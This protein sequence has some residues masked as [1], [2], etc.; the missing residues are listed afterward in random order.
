[1]MKWF[2]I[3]GLLFVSVSAHA[4]D[5]KADA[6]VLLQKNLAKAK[7]R[8]VDEVL[9]TDAYPN[10]SSGTFMVYVQQLYKDIRV[11]NAVRTLVF[12]DG[13]LV[14]QRGDFVTISKGEAAKKPAGLTA[15]QAL[16]RAIVYLRITKPA[17]FSETPIKSIRNKMEQTFSGSGVSQNAIP[18]TLMWLPAADGSLT[19]CWEIGI[20]PVE[21]ND[22]WLIRVGAES[23]KI[24]NQVNLTVYCNW[25]NHEIGTVTPQLHH[26]AHAIYPEPVQS[27][28][29]FALD[30]ASYRVIPYPFES[31]SHSGGTF[32]VVK[33]PWA[34]AGTGNAATTLKWHNDGT[35][36]YN[37]TRGNNVYAQEDT[38]QD[39]EFGIPATSSTAL[40]RLT[41]TS[42]FDPA[43]S[44]STAT[45]QAAAITNLFYWNNIIHDVLYQYGFD[46]VSGN[47][48]N[49]NSGR[50][51][52][53]GD[54]VIADAQDGSG[55]NN[56]NFST[57]PDGSRPR[58]QM[59][60]FSPPSGSTINRDGD[61]DNGI[62]V[63]EYAHGISNRLTG[64]ASQV[65]CL[66]NAEQMGEGWSDYYGLMLTTNWQNLQ[67]TD[68]GIS[69]PIGTYALAQSTTGSGIRTYPY[70]TNMTTNPLTYGQVASAPEGSV[71]Y[72]GSIWCTMIWDMTWEIIKEVGTISPSLYSADNTGGNAIAMRLVTE[73]L[74]IQPCSP[75]FV[76]GRDA[77]LTA[78][79][80]LYGGRYSCA[81][82]RAFARR[83]LGWSASQGSPFSYTDQV[84]AFDTPSGVISKTTAI[85]TVEQGEEVTYKITVDCRCAPV[86]NQA[87]IDSLPIGSTYVSGGTYNAAT[88]SVSF[89]NI[90]LPIGKDT[91]FFLKVINT[92][93]FST[94]IV[95]FSADGSSL[96]QWVSSQLVGS[97]SWGVTQT[98]SKSPSWSWHMPN[99]GDVATTALTSPPYSLGSGTTLFSFWH[100]LDFEDSFDGGVVE[101]S[102]DNGTSWSDLGNYMTQN[103]YNFTI[104]NCCGTYIS[105]KPAFSGFS[106]VFEET[107]VDLSSFKN[108][109]IRLR[110]LVSEDYSVN[111]A[112]W[113]I[114][115]VRLSTETLLTNRAYLRSESQITSTS[116]VKLPVI[117]ARDIQSITSGSW[118]SPSTWSCNCV[119]LETDIVTINSSHTVTVFEIT[120][121]LRRLINKN[122]NLLLNNGSLQFV[123]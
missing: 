77:I 122:G 116:T 62:I 89:G 52:L 71:H 65:T 23:G 102:T 2:I 75:G 69:R 29:L 59:F 64:G 25:D 73:A 63:H 35:N 16:D 66:L 13:D 20:H 80:L 104:D 97:R 119:P 60:L 36:E 9:I 55:I 41:F 43:T 90:S 57:P 85:S 76:D 91:S 109:T 44:P 103:G 86:V 47:F 33:S 17:T 78:D 6:Q 19:L 42:V 123:H 40:P 110:F 84:V 7:L 21:S 53:G 92:I 48:Q 93:P 32:M 70:T 67:K 5:Y 74:K 72:I 120:A 54:Y 88:H 24:I 112:G 58:M 105:G 87:V 111:Y 79:T 14:L 46:E 115:D 107:I 39:N 45:N 51:G 26:E 82:W 98:R 4:Q 114:D 106:G 49:D 8:S 118:N 11:S 95:H 30:S 31:P 50:G 101:I 117:L 3:T 113:Y 56:A 37:Y 99:F 100:Y 15:T 108:S 18:A 61:L 96:T 68:G 22:S 81:I 34:A 121:P 27:K 28:A 83:G 1:M 38:N 94:P 10:A 12:K